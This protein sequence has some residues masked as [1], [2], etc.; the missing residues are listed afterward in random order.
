MLCTPGL[1]IAGKRKTT[2]M[3]TIRNTAITETGKLYEHLISG[4]NIRQ[5]DAEHI[6]IFLY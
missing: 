6:Q 3:S 5:N 2:N 4:R 1:G